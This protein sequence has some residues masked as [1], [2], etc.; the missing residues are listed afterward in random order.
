MRLNR[1]TARL[2][3]TVL[4]RV[5]T[6]GIL[7]SWL[8]LGWSMPAAGQTPLRIITVVPAV[9]NTSVPDEDGDFPAYI[10]I[11]A[12][13]TM[14]ISGHFLSDSA[15]LP[16]KWQ[17]PAGYALTQGQTLRVFA[18]GKNRRPTGPN[19]VLH[20]SFAFDCSVPFC[21]L[22][23]PSQA[24]M[25]SYRDPFD[26]C[27][28]NGVTILGARSLARYWVPVTDPGADWALPGFNDKS[29]L[30]GY[31]G[32][33][34]EV[35]G[36]PY[37]AGLVLYHTMDKVHLEGKT[38]QDVSGPTLHVGKIEGDFS[39]VG[40]RIE[41]GLEYKADATRHV[42][43]AHHAELVPG[44]AAFSVALWFRPLRGGVS[45]A[46]SAFTEVL[47]SKQA[48][49]TVPSQ[50]GQGWSIVRSQSGTFVQVVSSVGSRVVPLGPT[51]AGQWHHVVLVVDRAGSVL[52][53]YLNGKRIG[54]A[55]LS[56]GA[57]EV[58]G[59]TVDLFEGRDPDGV[60]PFAGAL[61]DLAIWR[62]ALSEAQVQEVY[63][64]GLQGKSLLDGSAFP[65]ANKIYG[66]L[67]AT[68]VLSKMRGVSSTLYVR[69]P[70]NLPSVPALATGLRLRVHYDDGFVA[71]LNGAEVA[72]RNAPVPVDS[73]SAA[74]VDRP[75]GQALT[76]ESID[77]GGYLGL[78]KPGGN[79]LAFQAL[80]HD[81]AAE[82][83]LLA[84]AQLCLEVERPTTNPGGD[85]VKET[86]GRDFWVAFPENY[87]QEPDTPLRLSLC[88][89]GPPGTQGVVDLPGLQVGGFPRNFAIPAGGAITLTL[90]RAAE[91]S[92]PESIEAKAVHIVASADVAVYGTTRMDY[93]TDTFLGLPTKCLGTEY[94]VCSYRNVFQGIPILNGTQFAIVA[95]ANGTK[96]SIV[97]KIAVGGHPANV[98]FVVELDRGETYQL[99]NEG[100]QPAD[101]TGTEIRS[102][103]PVGV[104]GSHRCANVQS[105]NQFFCD[106][107]V[108]EL[109][110]LSSW[111]DSYFVVPLATRKSDTVRIISGANAN[112]VTLSSAGGGQS[113]VLQRGETRELQIEQA[114]RIVCRGPALVAQYSNSSDFDQVTAADP[115]MSLIQPSPTWLSQYRLCTPV[116][117]EFENNYLN[118]VALTE[119]L[120]DSTT[121]NG[122]SL[123]AWNPAEISRGGFPG[124]AA[125]ARVRLQ[126]GTAYHVVGKSA[127]GL[128]AYGFSEYDSYGYPGGMR[129][130]DTSAPILSCPAEVTID[131]QAV[132]GA[133][134]CV[135]AVP[136]FTRRIDIFDDCTPAGRLKVT[137][138]PPPGTMLPPGFYNVTVVA[139]DGHGNQAQCLVTL[140][141]DTK[142]SEQQFGAVV[143][144]NPALE[145]TVWGGEADPDK[146][147]I[148][149][150]FEQAL[151]SDP[152]RV[153]SLPSV[154]EIGSEIG[155]TGSFAT[156]SIPRLLA[157]GGPVV[158][159]EGVGVLDGS[160][161][162]SGP[163]LFEELPGLSREIPGGKHERV[164]YRIRQ[165]T[166][167][168]GGSS[169][170]LRLKLGP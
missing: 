40:G 90:P 58:I 17:V 84:P 54:T 56:G 85:C 102:N 95:V 134:T 57:N 100:G 167:V 48:S 109:L 162:E 93:T 112:L 52:V 81:P 106:T 87:A 20:T 158:E 82:R 147:G 59:G 10:E 139:V 133:A 80:S 7:W 83:F 164:V 75:D 165:P 128:T 168:G 68:D 142:W 145:A 32:F 96:V 124:G 89:A 146:D 99:R 98:P 25:D 163:D 47:V 111:G 33:G 154:I 153:T 79:V 129:F 140:V 156:V 94:L 67:I 118:L 137:Q 152:N 6:V 86:N 123:P 15:N 114:T 42:R 53:G 13:A 161:W 19:G 5:G 157:E 34:F 76:G 21:G 130:G 49:S 71:Y 92:G 117:S 170:F 45:S 26:L 155:P 72:R 62:G 50:P 46:G 11:R 8:W 148:P 64:A 69:I 44:S 125:F 127:L 160:P 116:A 131:C 105:V 43:V 38:L 166:V 110:P 66:G 136:D 65:A 70:F 63:G 9:A 29:W 24:P 60:A 103:K 132:P 14:A 51:A 113:F 126:P 150:R 141:V 23:S 73:F 55:A 16:G 135:A 122:V 2:F 115:F 88:I 120:L 74:T 39:M 41:Q 159:L 35:G 121:I 149:N 1:A 138:T 77:L 144:S 104:F 4:R 107:V 36:S 78:L 18:S 30:R 37:Q 97:P 101:L 31:T 169:Y 3:G 143:A 91:L 61:D 119:S 12:L 27:E 28:C 151:G 22:Y 108:E